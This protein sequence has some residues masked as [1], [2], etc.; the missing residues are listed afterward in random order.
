M[1]EMKPKRWNSGLYSSATDDWSTPRA[2]FGYLNRIFSFTLD[3]CATTD[4]AQC[5]R[6]FTIEQDGLLQS[7]Q[8][9]RVFMNP[10]YGAAISDW[11]RKA[12]QEALDGAL[13]VCLIPARTDTRW[14]HELVEQ[15]EIHLLKGRLKFGDGK[16]TAPFPSAIVIYYPQGLLGDYVGL[17]QSI[18]QF[19]FLTKDGEEESS[20][21]STDKSASATE[22]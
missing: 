21:E 9:E 4:N 2:V 1:S 20:Q 3:P 18:L 10:P 13:V 12:I 16:D 8:H 11:L 6:F 15:G 5:E 7:W 19:A 22:V 17:G 14:W